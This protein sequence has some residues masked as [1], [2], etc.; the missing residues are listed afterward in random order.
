MIEINDSNINEILA[1]DKPVLVDFRAS[2]C[3][4][5]TMIA[6]IL[7]ELASTYEDEII[8]AKIDVDINSVSTQKYGVRNLPSVLYFKDGIVVDK[9]IGA[10]SKKAYT[11]KLVSNGFIMFAAE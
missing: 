4:P 6:P 10:G 5:C 7:D 9:Q 3:G 1:S 2:W 8:V 11:D